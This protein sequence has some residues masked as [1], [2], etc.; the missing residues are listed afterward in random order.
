M[1]GEHGSHALLI[2]VRP[3]EYSHVDG[4]EGSTPDGAISL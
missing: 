1:F 4:A 3:R 2:Y